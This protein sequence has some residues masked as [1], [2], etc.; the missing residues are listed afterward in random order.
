[1][2]NFG[3]PY[4]QAAAGAVILGRW[5]PGLEMH[6]HVWWVVQIWRADNTASNRRCSNGSRLVSHKAKRSFLLGN[7]CLTWELQ[8]T[9]VVD[10]K[11]LRVSCGVG[12]GRPC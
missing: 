11:P 10:I 12:Q 4:E 3:Q 2:S 5:D 9:V 7:L 6:A 1:M 8:I